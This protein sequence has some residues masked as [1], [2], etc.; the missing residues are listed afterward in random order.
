MKYKW[1]KKLVKRYK[2]CGC[3]K[4]VEATYDS[5]DNI[6]KVNNGNWS[7]SWDIDTDQPV[8]P[9]VAARYDWDNKLLRVVT[10]F[11]GNVREV[12]VQ[13]KRQNF[14]RYGNELRVLYPDMHWWMNNN[15]VFY[16]DLKKY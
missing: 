9:Q 5:Q 4:L 11:A 14:T 12:K 2:R 8:H 15:D 7:P 13:G 6:V 3:C 16:I 10:P 1:L